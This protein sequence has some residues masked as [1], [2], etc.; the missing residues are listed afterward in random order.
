M[1]I[2]D[3]A[4]QPCGYCRLLTADQLLKEDISLETGLARDRLCPTC[5]PKIKQQEI[6]PNRCA[7]KIY[8]YLL[9]WEFAHHRLGATFASDTLKK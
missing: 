2:T 5:Y 4:L 1:A 7:H 9:A 8:R 6:R 3:F